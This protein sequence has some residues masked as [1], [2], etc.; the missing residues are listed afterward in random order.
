VARGRGARNQAFG[1]LL[2]V[3]AAAC[4]V[5]LAVA[6]WFPPLGFPHD[7][8]LGLAATFFAAGALYAVHRAYR[9][10]TRAD[11]SIQAGARS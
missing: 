8:Y 7:A 5:L 4:A 10:R 1:W 2:A 9:G 6:P 3:V 11:S